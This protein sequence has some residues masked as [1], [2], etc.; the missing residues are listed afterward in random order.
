MGLPSS[1]GWGEFLQT[2]T[3]L[4]Q[5]G[6]RGP[7]C[8]GLP[9]EFRREGLDRHALGF[10]EEAFE[11]ICFRGFCLGLLAGLPWFLVRHC[12]CLSS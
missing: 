8:M 1:V 3:G 2:D 12:G 7:R 10:A 4:F 6:E 11:L 5:A 9:A